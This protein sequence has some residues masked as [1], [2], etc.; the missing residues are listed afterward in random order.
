MLKMVEIAK[1]FPR[2]IR[3]TKSIM[4]LIIKTYT[5]VGIPVCLL[6]NRPIPDVPP[7]I[8][9]EPDTNK[10]K[11]A[12]SKIFPIRIIINRMISLDFLFMLMSFLFYVKWLC[13]GVCIRYVHK[14]KKTSHVCYYM[15]KQGKITIVYL[16]TSE[17]VYVP[18]WIMH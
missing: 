16:Y 10:T 14:C 17:N 5:E 6:R 8:R 18:F 11:P 13:L 15:T 2:K 7:V 9:P 1:R 4:A 12:E 3:P